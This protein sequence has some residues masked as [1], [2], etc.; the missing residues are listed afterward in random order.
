MAQRTIFGTHVAETKLS[1]AEMMRRMPEGTPNRDRQRILLAECQE[2]EAF[3]LDAVEIFLMAKMRERFLSWVEEVGNLES[4]VRGGR[5]AN[6]KPQEGKENGKTTRKSLVRPRP[7]YDKYMKTRHWQALFS[8]AVT[9]YGGCVLCN[10]TARMCLHH[11]H[12]NTVP[13]ELQRDVAILCRKHHL[14]L[15]QIIKIQVPMRPPEGVT[16][17][18]AKEGIKYP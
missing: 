13:N 9:H 16:K 15:H 7:W 8:G 18:F 3:L 12:Y 17:L 14:A 2:T 4:I 1:I 5:L 6:Q 11:R 10:S